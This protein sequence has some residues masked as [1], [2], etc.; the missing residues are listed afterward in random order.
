[1]SI[2]RWTMVTWLGWLLGIPSVALLALL[3]EV[4]HLG[5]AQGWVG[6]GMGLAV[7]LLQGRS[8]R[9]AGISAVRWLTA[10]S[11]ALAAPFLVLD[12]FHALGRGVPYSLLICVAIGGSMV[13]VAQGQLLPSHA[14]R[15][16][17]VASSVGWFMAAAAAWG[18]DALFRTHRVAGIVGA[19]EYLGLIA[20][21]GL[22]LGLATGP[23]AVRLSV[24]QRA[25]T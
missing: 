1:M 5:G 13:G 14:K 9:R 7:G 2:A 15:S 11:L 16:W 22:L 18:A 3:G 24:S 25:A 10:T 8:L 19:L 17:V 20:S 12:V 21:G 6:A 4:L 23:L